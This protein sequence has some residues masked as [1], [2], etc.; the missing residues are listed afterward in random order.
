MANQPPSDAIV[1]F[2]GT[3]LSEWTSAKTEGK[4]AAWKVDNGYM[5]AVPK[6][7]S[8]KT[9]KAFGDI[10]LHLEFAT[11]KEVIGEGQKP[12]NSGVIFMGNYEVQVLNSFGNVTYA[13]GQASAV[14]GQKPPLVNASK[15]PGTWQRY[16][17][18]FRAPVFKGKRLVK[19]A[20]V[21][22]FHNGVL[23]QDHWVIKGK[24]F[25]KKT[26]AYEAHEG[27]LPFTL[28]DH[29]QPIRYRNVWVR[30]LEKI[31]CSC[32]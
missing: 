7:G 18:I 30:E 9:K 32:K 12:G 25:H 29:G 24:T 23:T 6:S 22:V 27:K 15:K 10:Q 1:L 13:D 4:P 21:T 3:D 2:D 16:D 19:P 31:P 20:V 28:Q 14:Y 5:E 8:I 17:I 11:P 26:P